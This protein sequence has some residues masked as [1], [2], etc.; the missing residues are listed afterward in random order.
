VHSLCLHV[1]PTAG[2]IFHKSSTG[3]RLWFYA[4]YLMTS[5]RRG[6]SVKQLEGELGVT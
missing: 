3:L 2:T 1:D 6:I 4:V 5:T